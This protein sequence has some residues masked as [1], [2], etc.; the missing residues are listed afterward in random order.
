MLLAESAL[1]DG[2]GTPFVYLSLLLLVRSTSVISSSLVNSEST[3][4]LLKSWVLDII[5]YNVIGGALLGVVMGTVVRELLKKSKQLGW[6]EKEDA[7]IFTLSL[8]IAVIGLGKFENHFIK[9]SGNS[10][11]VLFR[12]GLDW[13]ERALSLCKC[14][15]I[16]LYYNSST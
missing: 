12:R 14:S 16:K 15:Q 9:A 5:F 11:F 8:A 10:C 7:L 2:A 13:S 3:W 1:N 6:T 4:T